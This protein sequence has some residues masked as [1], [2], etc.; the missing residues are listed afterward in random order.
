MET[1]FEL[2]VVIMPSSKETH[3]SQVDRN[4]LPAVWLSVQ[5]EKFET[6]VQNIL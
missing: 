3:D 6:S 2:H 1:D 5:G 4:N